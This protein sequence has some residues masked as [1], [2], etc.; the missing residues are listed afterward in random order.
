MGLKGRFRKQILVHRWSRLLV[1]AAFAIA[2]CRQII[3][4]CQTDEDV[5]DF[6]NRRSQNISNTPVKKTDE[7]PVK[8]SDDKKNMGNSVKLIHM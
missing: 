3:D 4:G 8:T 5:D 7:K 6:C 2:S 1:A